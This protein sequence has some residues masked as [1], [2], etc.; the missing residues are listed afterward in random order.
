MAAHIDFKS[1]SL[2]ID[3]RLDAG[4]RENLESHLSSCRDCEE[5]FSS[6]KSSVS[7]VNRLP[8]VKES[9][10]FDFEFRRKMDEELA[11]LEGKR[12]GLDRLKD[13]IERL[14][15]GLV[16]P[17]P[18][19]V[20]AVSVFTVMALIMSSIVWTRFGVLPAIASVEGEVSIYRSVSGEWEKALPGMRLTAGDVLSVG[21]DSRV[22][23]E[24]KKY[25]IMLKE[26]TVAKAIYLDRFFG[27]GVSA[28]SLD[29]GKMLVATKRGFEGSKFKIDSPT[30]QVE[31]KGT[32]FMVKV[33]PMDGHK[34][35]IGVLDGVVEV[36]SKIET[37]D[38]SSMVLVNAGKATEV[39]P[40][41]APRPPRYQ[42]EKEWEEMQEIYGLG[43]QPV[44]ALLV[45]MTPRRVHELLRPAGLYISDKKAKDMPKK[46]ILIANKINR[47]IIEGDKEKHLNAIQSLEELLIKYP[48]A[49]YDV[50]FLF[51]I[52]VY[53]YYLDEN[54]K[55]IAALER[56][57]NGHVESK[58]I[59]LALCAEGIIYEKSIKDPVN[60]VLNYEAVLLSYPESLEADEARAGLERLK[61]D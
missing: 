19:L 37:A 53:Y 10:H 21:K 43:D 27:G 18:V 52:A 55:A 14:Q 22:N 58:L 1:L 13:I 46:A 28:Y 12:S 38:A 2:Y 7:L 40:G 54:E 35:W 41:K 50:Q 44:V 56:I 49:K 57:V 36:K 34:T 4:K 61:I 3:D 16:R 32:G 15:P 45:S 8:E 39:G 42:R 47:A 6:L 24:S 29:Q 26:D 11:R 48:S 17:I 5:I 31:A 30:A 25:E 59:S 60:A 33:S 20:K 23:I 9:E 51:F